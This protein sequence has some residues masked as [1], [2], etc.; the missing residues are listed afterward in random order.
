MRGRMLIYE[1]LR[2]R[3]IVDHLIHPPELTRL[4][5]AV[6]GWIEE[7]KMFDTID[8]D[9]AIIG[10]VAFCN[11]EGRK[12]D[13]DI[14][15]HATLLWRTA[16]RRKNIKPINEILHGPIVVLVGDPAFFGAL[17]LEAA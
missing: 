8:L 16:L 13:L 6:G 2:Y 14:N 7:V 9:D 15:V 12:Q 1:P 10:C 4:Q 11:G 17:R 5:H 3:P